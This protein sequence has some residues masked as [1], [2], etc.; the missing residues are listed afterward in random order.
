RSEPERSPLLMSLAPCTGLPTSPCTGPGNPSNFLPEKSG[1]APPIPTARSPRE[2]PG[3]W[4]KDRRACPGARA[5]GPGARFAPATGVFHWYSKP[6]SVSGTSVV[7]MSE[8]LITTDPVGEFVWV[9]E[10]RGF[11]LRKASHLAHCP[12]D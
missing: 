12:A 7:E 6:T 11:S 10:N 4:R 9:V 1:N 2:R 8:S 5:G 3:G